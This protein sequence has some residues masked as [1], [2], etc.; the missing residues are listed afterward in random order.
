MWM[1]LRAVSSTWPAAVRVASEIILPKMRSRVMTT[2][3]TGWIGR[4]GARRQHRA[5][6]AP[7][8]AVA[9]EGADVGEAAEL[10]LVDRRLGPGGQG[11]AD[12]GDDQADVVRRH[13]HPGVALDLEDRPQ[14]EAQP[15]HEQVGLVA[16]LP[17]QGEELVALELAPEALGDQ[18]DLGGPI[19]VKLAAKNSTT[20]TPTT[21]GTIRA[22]SDAS[23]SVTSLC[24][25]EDVDVA[26][27]GEAEV[28]V[29]LP[30]RR[31]R[32]RRRPGPRG[33]GRARDLAPSRSASSEPTRT[34][35]WAAQPVVG[36]ARSP[37]RSRR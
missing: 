25:R 37:R 7:L 16:G 3:P 4:R 23:M 11:G 6:H 28:E 26:E 13:L 2:K 24:L 32:S 17:V 14:L 22:T 33:G 36:C 5:L 9:E 12:L 8:A 34:R 18:A 15:G 20:R 21:I 30:R 19:E 10:G 35:A 27:Q 29:A 1:T 31:P